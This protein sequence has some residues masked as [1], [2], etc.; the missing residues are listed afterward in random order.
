MPLK[1]GD[2]VIDN[3]SGVIGVVTG[4][5][6]YLDESDMSIRVTSKTSDNKLEEN[7]FSEK[8]LSKLSMRA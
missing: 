2:E 6:E 8:R 1:N 7:W 3:A 4:V 5:C